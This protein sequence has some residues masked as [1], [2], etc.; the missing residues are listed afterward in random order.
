MDAIPSS[1]GNE[2]GASDLC[3]P[4]LTRPFAF[5]EHASWIKP[6]IT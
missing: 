5:C 2:L 1:M 4:G 6:A 3:R